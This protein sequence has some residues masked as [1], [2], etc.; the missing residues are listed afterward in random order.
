[1]R[2]HFTQVGL[3]FD[4]HGA[5]LAAG[6]IE[7]LDLSELFIHDSTRPRAGGA[8]RRPASVFD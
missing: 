8:N 3:N 1:M 2:G 6:Q 5:A 7:K 4:R